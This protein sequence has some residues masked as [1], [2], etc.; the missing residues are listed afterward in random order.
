LKKAASARKQQ[1]CSLKELKKMHYEKY[2]TDISERYLKKIIRISAGT[3]LIGGRAVYLHVN[4]NFRQA[5]GRN[6]SG[7]RDIDIGIHVDRT[8][9]IDELK[10]IT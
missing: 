5:R 3:V 8:W 6:Y 9:S 10:N 7:S 4:R 1:T 2:E